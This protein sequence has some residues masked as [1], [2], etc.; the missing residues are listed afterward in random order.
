MITL[1]D[2]ADKVRVESKEMLKYL[3]S[4]KYLEIYLTTINNNF[5][6]LVFNKKQT[7]L[8]HHL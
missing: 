6:Y 1:Y 2:M 4:I 7:T 8:D 5:L 3:G